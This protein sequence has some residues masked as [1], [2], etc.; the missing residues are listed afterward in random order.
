MKEFLY[1]DQ[2]LSPTKDL[3]VTIK[4]YYTFRDI[5]SLLWSEDF[6][7]GRII[8]CFSSVEVNI[9]YHVQWE[10]F[11]KEETSRSVKV[12]LLQVCPKCMMSSES[13]S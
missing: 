10:L 2:A 8:D 11:F 1:V 12:W 9:T 3:L 5:L 6:T 13:G 7:L 4:I